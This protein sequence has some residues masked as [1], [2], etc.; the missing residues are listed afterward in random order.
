MKNIW[1]CVKEFKKQYNILI[2]NGT[3]NVETSDNLIFNSDSL[4]VNGIIYTNLIDVKTSFYAYSLNIVDTLI[5]NNAKYISLL[6]NNIQGK[7]YGDGT[8]IS[9]IIANNI[10]ISIADRFAYFANIYFLKGAL[11][12]LLTNKLVTSFHT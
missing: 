6:T 5:A 2:G 7:F 4:Y 12:N 1:I 3:N 11:R 8:N 9:N 10:N